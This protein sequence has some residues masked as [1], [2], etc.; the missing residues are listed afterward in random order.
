MAPPSIKG[1]AAS[2]LEADDRVME[3]HPG[4]IERY[5][6]AVAGLSDTLAA[7]AE[8]YGEAATLLRQLVDFIEIRPTGRGRP[9]EITL[10]GRLAELLS[11]PIRVFGPFRKSAM[12]VAGERYFLS[13]HLPNLRY[14][15]RSCA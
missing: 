9:P 7:G 10:H 15:L 5:T 13:P 3:L 6:R 14:H 4:A 2:A 11:P 1:C 8:H 12:L